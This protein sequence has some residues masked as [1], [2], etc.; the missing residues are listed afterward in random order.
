MTISRE[1]A[2]CKVE[3]EGHSV[4]NASEVCIV[5][6]GVKFPADGIMEGELERLIEIETRTVRAMKE[7]VLGN[8]GLSIGKQ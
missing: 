8:K 2:G 1:T 5:Y 7:R 3:V 4:E 6:L